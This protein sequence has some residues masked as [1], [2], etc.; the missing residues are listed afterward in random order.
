MAKRRTRSEKEKA[1]HSFSLSWSPEANKDDGVKG[2]FKNKAR[3][4]SAK[5]NRPKKAML[6]AK[7]DS[8]RLIKKD[9]FKSVFI[10]SLI[11]TLEV[12]IYLAWRK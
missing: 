10:A 8:L 2:Q 6:L 5:A 9:V 4:V 12:V 7:D 3:Q 1:V 11:I